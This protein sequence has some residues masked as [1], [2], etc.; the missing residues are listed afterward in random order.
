MGYVILSVGV[1]M[2]L[3]SRGGSLK[4]ASLAIAGGIFHMINHAAFKGL[5][6]L[7]AGAIEYSTGTRDLREMG[8]LAKSMPTT[9]ATSFAASLSISGIPPFNGFF[10]KLIIIVAAV[11]A[12]FYLLAA[13]AAIVSIITLASFMKFQ[14]Y[15]FYNKD[16][17]RKKTD[18]REVPLPMIL[19]MVVLSI[20][21]LLLSLLAFPGIREIILTPATDILM[22]PSK[23][24]TF[25]IGL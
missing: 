17:E 13:L 16:P 18:V 15:A 19:S 25:I 11:M 6:F 9:S 23:Y 22:D 20:I 8:G 12:H 4:I 5:L 10:S 3:I 2:I 24:S 7:N 1:G 21:C 14:R